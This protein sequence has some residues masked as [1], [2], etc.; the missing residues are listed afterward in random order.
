MHVI[1]FMDPETKVKIDQIL[2]SNKGY[3]DLDEF[4]SRAIA[5]QLALELSSSYDVKRSAYPNKVTVN[6]SP[7][8]IRKIIAPKSKESTGV[9]APITDTQINPGMIGLPST[10]PITVEVRGLPEAES[11]RPLWGQINRLGPSKL[12]LRVLANMLVDNGTGWL[13]L[14][15]VAASVSEQSPII[16][17]LLEIRDKVDNRKRGEELSAAFPKREKSSLQRFSNQYLGYYAIESNQPKGILADLS[18][19]NI[20]KTEEGIVEIGLTQPGLVFSMLE[21]PLIDTIAL[22]GGAA[23]SPLSNE[24]VKF[25][26]KHFKEFRPGEYD[27]LAYVLKAVYEGANNPS[28]LLSSVEE[29]FKSGLTWPDATSAVIGTMRAGAVS[30]L[31]ELG[32]L[33]IEK[34]GSRSKYKTTEDSKMLMG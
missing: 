20:R 21:S 17:R 11:R 10:T 4:I 7:R 34:D 22:K 26:V 24:E 8:S 30:K 19:I 5:N 18:F 31:V 23:K 6:E 25:L 9:Q 14:K 33:T 28:S 15:L 12:P 2:A 1:M 3:K 29:Y 16:R 32:F 13:D 27:F